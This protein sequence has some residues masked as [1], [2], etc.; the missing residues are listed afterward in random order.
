MKIETQLYKI[1]RI[2]KKSSSKREI[3]NI[4][5]Q[6]KKTGKV[7]SKQTKFIPKEI[8]KRTNKAQSQQKNNIIKMR[9]KIKEIEKKKERKIK[10]DQ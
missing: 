3:H 7:S 10:K 6:L 9:V 2:A 5:G 8:R 1:Y 4:T